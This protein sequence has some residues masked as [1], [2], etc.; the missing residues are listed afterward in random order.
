MHP[1]GTGASLSRSSLS[2]RP[3]LLPC[4]AVNDSRMIPSDIDWLAELA[5]CAELLEAVAEDH[6]RLSLVD[7]DLRRRLVTA[8]GRVSPPHPPPQRPPPSA[9]LPPDPDRPPR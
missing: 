4:P 3:D 7:R 5:R 2:P 8:A 9:P 6:T 1:L